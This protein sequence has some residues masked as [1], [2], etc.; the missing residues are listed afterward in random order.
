MPSG[1]A[2][3]RICC[4]KQANLGRLAVRSHNLQASVNNDVQGTIRPKRAVLSG[5]LLWQGTLVRSSLQCHGCKPLP[6]SRGFRTAPLSLGP[7]ASQPSVPVHF[8][9]TAGSFMFS[10]KFV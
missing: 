9:D 4:A 6:P 8:S 3:P 10:Y 7:D 5:K 2:F 1:A